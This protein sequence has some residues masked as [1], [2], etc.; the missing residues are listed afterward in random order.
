MFIQRTCVWPKCCDESFCAQ[1]LQ[2]SL[3]PHAMSLVGVPICSSFCSTP[4]PT[5]TPSPAALTEIRLNPSATP[6]SEGQSGHL[7]D[8]TPHTR[9]EGSRRGSPYHHG[10]RDADKLK[11]GTEAEYVEEIER[12]RDRGRHRRR[13]IQS[14]SKSA[15]SATLWV[16]GL[17]PVCLSSAETES[18]MNN[19]CTAVFPS[20]FCKNICAVAILVLRPLAR[21]PLRRV[22]KDVR[23]VTFC[24][25]A[26][27]VEIGARVR[28][29]CHDR[30]VSFTLH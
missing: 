15:A 29:A 19:R 6:L 11:S 27:Y 10:H 7:S 1:S 20:P 17:D 22:L 26:L 30:D 18:T 16:G 8:P 2:K 25:P 12:S 14:T 9:V 23:L 5:W 4:P 21:V 28:G 24:V 13:P 3:H